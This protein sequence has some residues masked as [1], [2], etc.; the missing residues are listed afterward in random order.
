MKRFGIGPGRQVRHRVDLPEELRN[1]VARI[2]ALAELIEIRKDPGERV[3]GL[4]D[5]EFRVV[6]AL[7]IKAPMMLDELFFEES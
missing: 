1:H 6:F 4:R 7:L 2:G 3:F 5:G